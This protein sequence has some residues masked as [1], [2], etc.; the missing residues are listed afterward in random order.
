MAKYGS[1]KYGQAKYGVS[2]SPTTPTATNTPIGA[3][4][5]EDN[6]LNASIGFGIGTNLASPNFISADS[7]MDNILR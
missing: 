5:P 6:G 2:S 3:I 1:F 7:F 4:A